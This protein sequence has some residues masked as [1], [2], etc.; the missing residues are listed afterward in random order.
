M[1]D[2]SCTAAL[3][4]Y[5]V[6]VMLFGGIMLFGE[7]FGVAWML[8]SFEWVYWN[9]DAFT[10]LLFGLLVW[11]WFQLINA[12]L[13][14]IR[15]GLPRRKKKK[16]KC[17]RNWRNQEKKF[18]R[19]KLPYHL[20][21]RCR[22][23]EGQRPPRLDGSRFPSPVCSKHRRGGGDLRVNVVTKRRKIRGK[24]SNLHAKSK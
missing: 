14:V 1:F 23:R 15:M 2:T 9:D 20:V 16:K 18:H 22:R 10:V 8:Q 3:Y 24:R 12:C 17:Q 11:G 7:I 6:L 5:R 19:R 21:R 13:R 4:F